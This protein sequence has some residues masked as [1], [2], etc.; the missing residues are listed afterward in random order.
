MITLWSRRLR[1]TVFEKAEQLTNSAVDSREVHPLIWVNSRQRERVAAGTR[2]GVRH[3]TNPC[4]ETEDQAASDGNG[5]VSVCSP[6][7]I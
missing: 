5:L 2:S 1:L 4:H 6:D 7:G 3:V